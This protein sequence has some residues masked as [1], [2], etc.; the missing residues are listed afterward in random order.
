MNS[1]LKN[2]LDN[3][4]A[5]KS[6]AAGASQDAEYKKP[7]TVILP[8]SSE[9]KAYLNETRKISDATIEAYKLGVSEK[10]GAIVI[11]IIDETGETVR[12]NF[13]HQTGEKLKIRDDEAKEFPEA[14]GKPILLG[15]HLA[16]P[17]NGALVISFGTYDALALHTAG[18]LNACSVPGGDQNKHWLDL[19]F[20]WLEQFKEIVL[21]TDNE[22][23]LSK[24]ACEKKKEWLDNLAARLGTFRVKIVNSTAKDAN[25]LLVNGGVEAV[26]KAVKSAEYYK[27][28]G[29]V[30]LAENNTSMDFENAIPTGW[31]EFDRITAGIM[32]K[33]YTCLAGDTSAGKTT[34]TL[35]ICKAIVNDGKK[36]F[37]WAGEQDLD[38]IQNWVDLMFSDSNDREIRKAKRTGS[39]YSLIRDDAKPG[40]RSKYHD[41]FF[42]FD[43]PGF[44]D[45]TGTVCGLEEF[46]RMAE[47]AIRRHGCE[48]LILDNLTALATNE[49]ILNNSDYYQTQAK[50]VM[51]CKQMAKQYAVHF[52]VCAHTRKSPASKDKIVADRDNVEGLKRLINLADLVLHVKRLDDEQKKEEYTGVDT[53]I[54][55]Q[56]NRITGLEGGQILLKLDRHSKTFFE[57][58]TYA[59]AMIEHLD[60]EAGYVPQA[61]KKAEIVDDEGPF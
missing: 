28:L 33:R 43:R 52:I 55:I 57:I 41:P 36:V 4:V 44:E 21:W 53:V 2:T 56:K 30:R 15:T 16:K 34:I 59:Q 11:P 51:R 46:F 10:T 39:E 17:E 60:V 20:D 61:M 24:K 14:G 49:E 26:Q 38:E 25:D 48:V 6:L 58:E 7:K 54:E 50:A 31:M 42:A 45:S 37:Y 3:L 22:A 35:N 29:L 18:V 1:Q 9:A 5:I 27:Q 8:I 47:T 19:Q 12:V 40:I 23:N 13:R 32:P